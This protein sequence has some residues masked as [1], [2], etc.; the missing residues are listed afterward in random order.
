MNVSFTAEIDHI[1]RGH[2]IVDIGGK[3]VDIGP[4]SRSDVGRT[5]KFVKSQDS[6]QFCIRPAYLHKIS[7]SGNGLISTQNGHLNI[8]PVSPDYVA[9]YVDVVPHSNKAY[10]VTEDATDEAYPYHQYSRILNPIEVEW[11]PISTKHPLIE[12]EISE[13]RGST[14]YSRF[15]EYT[16]LK[17]KIN[18][19]N[20]RSTLVEGDV[21]SVQPHL[22]T[23]SDFPQ[24]MEA[25]L[26]ENQS[27]SDDSSNQSTTRQ[28]AAQSES[29]T[30]VQS[31]KD[32]SSDPPTESRS[33]S[34][35]RTTDSEGV[36]AGDDSKHKYKTGID[37]SGEQNSSSTEEKSESETQPDT[38]KP[39][40]RGEKKEINQKGDQDKE[41]SESS[42][43]KTNLDTL[44]RRALESTEEEM[45]NNVPRSTIEVTRYS[46]SSEVREYVK[47]RADGVCEGCDEPAPFTSETG[48]PYLHAHHVHELSSGGSDT[49]DSVIALCPNCHYRVHHGRKGGEYNDE[50]KQ[51]LESIEDSAADSL[52]GDTP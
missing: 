4:I 20:S 33:T 42:E 5:V 34:E 12:L 19:S 26:K 15:G 25:D 1:H 11:F 46:R 35:A 17:V 52:P 6:I 45:S 50:L 10:C 37:S 22:H 36:L 38:S 14:A 13:I 7:N 32:G 43:D 31:T 48:D 9:D 47:A 2:G 30:N 39:A 28:T 21:V 27:A 8:G 16:S 44:R 29:G 41:N 18:I 3:D 23:L 24:V 40:E 51:K 49:P